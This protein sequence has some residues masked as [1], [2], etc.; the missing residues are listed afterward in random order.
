MEVILNDKT[1]L[2]KVIR[3]KI[4]NIYFRFDENMNLVV[5]ANHYTSDKEIERLIEKNQKSLTNMMIKLEKKQEKNEEFWYLGNKYD[6]VYDETIKSI[7]F[8]DGVIY[9]SSDDMLS[10]FLKKQ[11]K[12]IFESEV[13]AFKNVI[14]TP[15][16]TLKIRKMKTRWGVCNYRS[17]TITLNSELIRY[18][19]DDLR[20]V[21]VHEMC[22]FT[23]HNHGALFWKMVGEYFPNYKIARKELRY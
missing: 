2:V 22:H 10:R 18:K 7:D 11:I 12:E 16:F 13:N 8:Q 19:K 21:I 14:P 17:N 15:S 3:K 20:Y 5:S 1:V 4:K 23:H 9:V 6:I